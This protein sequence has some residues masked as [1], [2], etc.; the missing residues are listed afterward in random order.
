MEEEEEGEWVRF[1]VIDQ[2]RKPDDKIDQMERMT[3]IWEDGRK[4]ETADRKGKK[5]K[6]KKRRDCELSAPIFVI[7]R[8]EMEDRR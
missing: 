5:G 6:T 1:S 2:V 3:L 7:D 8:W 4:K